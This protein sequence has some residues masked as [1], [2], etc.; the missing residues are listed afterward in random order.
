MTVKYLLEG[1]LDNG[2]EVVNTRINLAIVALVGND[3]DKAKENISNAGSMYTYAEPFDKARILWFQL[4]F[5]LTGG[6][7]D[8]EV[9]KIISE[10]KTVLSRIEPR[11][12]R[13]EFSADPVVR[14]LNKRSSDNNHQLLATLMDVVNRKKELVELEKFELWLNP[15]NLTIRKKPGRT[16]DIRCPK[17]GSSKISSSKISMII[18]IVVN[19]SFLFT[20]FL[21]LWWLI[22][23]IPFSFN[24]L[25]SVFGRLENHYCLNCDRNFFTIRGKYFSLKNEI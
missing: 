18:L 16:S 21:S 23:I 24:T 5:N 25:R 12:D 15:E 17:C 7:N 13:V 6:K 4:Y 2:Y 8:Q 14:Y 10:L 20:L 9:Y 1:L 19:L 3:L 22:L 11:Y